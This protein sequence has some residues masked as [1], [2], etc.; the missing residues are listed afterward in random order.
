MNQG[1]PPLNTPVAAKRPSL[2]EM[3]TPITRGDGTGSSYGGGLLM[4]PAPNLPP[5]DIS[6]NTIPTFSTDEGDSA[7]GRQGPS[8]LGA[9]V[10]SSETPGSNRWESIGG[11]PIVMGHGEE[12]SLDPTQF[13]PSTSIH[14]RVARGVAS[15]S[16][17]TRRN[18]N[19]STTS[20]SDVS[21]KSM[22]SLLPSESKRLLRVGADDLTATSEVSQELSLDLAE[23]PNLAKTRSDRKRDKAAAAAGGT[24][25]TAAAAAPS[26]ESNRKKSPPRRRQSESKP[27]RMED[28]AGG[29]SEP[30]NWF[31]GRQVIMSTASDSDDNSPNSHETNLLPNSF[32]SGDQATLS[33]SG[34]TNPSITRLQRKQGS[35]GTMDTPRTASGIPTAPQT[36]PVGPNVPKPDDELPDLRSIS[37]G[38]MSTSSGST[39]SG[40]REAS[41]NSNVFSDSFMDGKVESPSSS[42]TSHSATEHFFSGNK[43]SPVL[44]MAATMIVGDGAGTQESS[45]DPPTASSATSFNMHFD[46]DSAGFGDFAPVEGRGRGTLRSGESKTTIS[47]K[48]PIDHL[49]AEEMERLEQH[50]QKK[51]LEAL[52]TVA[53]KKAKLDG[54]SIPSDKHFRTSSNAHTDVASLGSAGDIHIM[55]TWI[56]FSK[57]DIK[58]DPGRDDDVDSMDEITLDSH[59]VRDE[60]RFG[61]GQ[62]SGVPAVKQNAGRRRSFGS[63]IRSSINAFRCRGDNWPCRPKN[64]YS[65]SRRPTVTSTSRKPR[66]E[67]KLS[68]R[69]CLLYADAEEDG[70][71][72]ALI[73]YDDTEI[74]R[75][76]LS[77][78]DEYEDL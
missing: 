74:G 57:K 29:S 51:I 41:A 19:S 73:G 58:E 31:G 78:I 42:Q 37:E 2:L 53:K 63:R 33:E 4:A 72:Q 20:N 48:T 12:G 52:A 49:P 61:N 47:T 71:D 70:F 35:S 27:R 26:S 56:K 75:A 30:Q 44:G 23:L 10:T 18:A 3:A 59:L 69:R 66:L 7:L 65:A 77:G 17:L 8:A 28:A 11:M 22:P 9:S 62:H 40:T 55:G 32:Y 60:M 16:E 24:T 25:A 34:S 6:S 14:D 15:S 36:L 68:S 50:K 46:S 43:S 45:N 76:G 38:S 21:A 67:K 1:A 39:T 5:R 64:R 54:K 13:L